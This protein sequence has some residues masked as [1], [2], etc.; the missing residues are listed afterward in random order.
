MPGIYVTGIVG[1]IAINTSQKPLGPFNSL[2]PPCQLMLIPA[3]QQR[4]QMS[5]HPHSWGMSVPGHL[6]SPVKGYNVVM[7]P[8]ALPWHQLLQR[9]RHFQGSG[10]YSLNA[11]AVQMLSCSNLLYAALGVETHLAFIF[12]ERK[13]FSP[14]LHEILSYCLCWFSSPAVLAPR[15]RWSGELLPRG[16][17]WLG[18]PSVIPNI[19][20][21]P[22]SSTPSCSWGVENVTLWII[23]HVW[24]TKTRAMIIPKPVLTPP[25]IIS[26]AKCMRPCMIVGAKCLK[27]KISRYSS[28]NMPGAL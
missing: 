2:I 13:A 23:F 22:V 9:T 14:G 15:N 10:K 6:P 28:F 7:D 20:S 4:Q 24:R 19:F 5:Q 17:S 8:A 18:A 21:I 27:E 3:S 11:L 16:L 26:A 25:K 1:V 12:L